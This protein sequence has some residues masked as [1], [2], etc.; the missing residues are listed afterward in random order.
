MFNMRRRLARVAR[1][2][3]GRPRSEGRL[4]GMLRLLITDGYPLAEPLPE[5]KVEEE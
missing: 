3:L 4:S 2:D 5:V 1:P